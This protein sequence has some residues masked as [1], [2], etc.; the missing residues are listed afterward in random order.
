[1]EVERR[2]EREESDRWDGGW[3]YQYQAILADHSD[4][5]H[6]H[7]EIQTPLGKN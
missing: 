2:E 5:H 6:H 7:T 3:L 1:M 4:H